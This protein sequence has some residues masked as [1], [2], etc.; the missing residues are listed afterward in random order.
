[1]ER[2]SLDVIRVP[3]EKFALGKWWA[4]TLDVP[5]L[6][7]I[8]LENI[9]NELFDHNIWVKFHRIYQVF[10]DTVAMASF[11]SDDI[12]YTEYS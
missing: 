4:P 7:L 10:F 3:T 5:F 8:I 6:F 9:F 12:T 2:Y 11:L 1:M